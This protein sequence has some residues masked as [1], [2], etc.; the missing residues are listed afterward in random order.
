MKKYKLEEE[1]EFMDKLRNDICQTLKNQEDI[2]KEMMKLV[3]SSEKEAN[4]HEENKENE[5]NKQT[6]EL[7]EIAKLE[8]ELEE[9]KPKKRN[10]IKII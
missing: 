3:L 10:N 8:K 6:D 4:E 2:T 7:D 9:E 5:E 1:F